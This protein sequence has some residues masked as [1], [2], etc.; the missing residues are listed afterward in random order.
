M[1]TGT[2]EKAVA[3][4]LNDP[5]LQVENLEVNPEKDQFAYPAPPP[6][7]TYDAKLKIKQ[8]DGVDF[9]RGETG[10]GKKY[11]ATQIEARLVIVGGDESLQRYD[12]WPIFDNFVSTLVQEQ[13]G[14][15]KIVGILKAV[16]QQVPAKT[17]DVELARLLRDKLA[18]EP[19]CKI[20]IDWE[21]SAET[22]QTDDRGKAIYERFKGMKRFPADPNKK[23]TYLPVVSIK[24][25]DATAQAIIL[26]YLP[27]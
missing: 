9:Y 22:G 17:T 6:A 7:G 16:G 3:I 4:D 11:L 25:T 27:A 13:A 26:K 24:G 8:K 5:N 21:A 15:N 1:A 2:D 10:K 12:N 14:T 18:G 23:G 20:T 19:S